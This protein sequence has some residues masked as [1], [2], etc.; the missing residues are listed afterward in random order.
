MPRWLLSSAVAITYG[1]SILKSPAPCPSFRR[2]VMRTL[3]ASIL[4]GLTTIALPVPTPV[5]A[6]ETPAPA[7]LAVVDGNA[8]IERDNNSEPA[9]SG[10]LLLSGDRLS[11]TSGRAEV[12]FPDGSSLAVD[13]YSAVDLQDDTLVRVL[14]G[15]VILQVAGA[16]DPQR[17]VRYQLDTPVASAINTTPGEFRITLLSG[18]RSEETELA[19]VRGTSAFS[20]ELGSITVRSGERSLARDNE[21]PGAVE[22]FNSAR[23]DEFDRWAQAR[24]NERLG[25]AVAA[26]YLPSDLRMYSGTFDRYGD[27][28]YEPS[29]GYVWYPTV[30]TSWRPYYN[31]YWRSYPRYGWTWVG[32]DV[33]GWPT[34]HYG[35][36]GYAGSR[37]FWVPGRQWGP[38]WVAWAS[39]PG[40]VSWCPLGFDNRPVFAL[41]LGYGNPWAG[42]AV[43][44]RQHFG[45]HA[46][47]TKYYPASYRGLPPAN[48]F[49]AHAAPPVA[50]PVAPPRAVPR[51]GAVATGRGGVAVPRNGSAYSTQTATPTLAP[52]DGARAVPRYGPTS[53]T[54]INGARVISRPPDAAPTPPPAPAPKEPLPDNART[55]RMGGTREWRDAPSSPPENQAAP[56][57]PQ[58]VPRSSSWRP[59]G[60]SPAARQVDPTPDSRIPS[61]ARSRSSERAEP[62]SQPATAS[63]STGAWRA[64]PRAA[65][66]P[67]SRPAPPPPASAPSTGARSTG[68][69]SAGSSAGSGSSEGAPASPPSPGRAQPR[70]GSSSPPPGNSSAPPAGARSRS[71]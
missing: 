7:H 4:A 31:G 65:A 37:W 59:L 29:Y 70:A 57:A 25:P 63:P 68:S 61:G 46:G 41:S 40:Y 43:L 52:A 56:A 2:G 38:S 21:A 27:W 17:V 71:R 44:P 30:A 10:M 1:R 54:V 51:P 11:T 35:R 18:P 19:V 50:A 24:R 42:W 67:P 49:V 16:R 55:F 5:Y 6:Q 58:A 3:R 36:W 33:W 26:Q 53:T 22:T 15:R 13:E 47:Y 45:I 14:S 62:S 23:F 8:T 34:H 69:S 60:T 32:H 48:T 66:P 28:Q 39:A 9:A 20:T 64:I 12:L